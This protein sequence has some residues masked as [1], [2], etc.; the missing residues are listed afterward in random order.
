MTILQLSIIW[1]HYHEVLNVYRLTSFIR[2][3]NIYGL[4]TRTSPNIEN[5]SVLSMEHIFFLF[6]SIC[7]ILRSDVCILKIIKYRTTVKKIAARWYVLSGCGCALN[8]QQLLLHYFY[9]LNDFELMD[10]VQPIV[11]IGLVKLL[12]LLLFNQDCFVFFKHF[13][14]SNKMYSQ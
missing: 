8:S 10:R 14:W 11:I 5:N 1:N 6:C 7:I 3:Y 9:Y 13:I 2:E 4:S 12:L